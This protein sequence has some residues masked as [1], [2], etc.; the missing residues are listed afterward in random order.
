MK[1]KVKNFLSLRNITL[2]LHDNLTVLVGDTGSGKSNVIRAI[3]AYKNKYKKEYNKHEYRIGDDTKIKLKPKPCNIKVFKSVNDFDDVCLTWKPIDDYEFEYIQNDMEIHT[4]KY[5]L[6]RNG[7]GGVFVR[8][9][10]SNSLCPLHY[11]PDVVKRVMSI[12]ILKYMDIED[13]PELL[14]IEHPDQ[15]LAKDVDYLVF[16]ALVKMAED[17]QTIITVNSCRFADD[18]IDYWEEDKFN[19]VVLHNGKDGTEFKNV[20]DEYNTRKAFQGW[21]IDFGLSSAVFHSGLISFT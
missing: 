1:L 4:C 15:N 13:K 5:T 9:R 18:H 10:K 12:S 11:I 14:V 6:E 16:S 20:R 21:S 8:E 19:I 3:D 17:I 7:Y 2:P